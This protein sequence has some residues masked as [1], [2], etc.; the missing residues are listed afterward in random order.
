MY[1]LFVLNGGQLVRG[2]HQLLTKLKVYK[3]NILVVYKFGKSMPMNWYVAAV[4]LCHFFFKASL[5]LLDLMVNI[6]TD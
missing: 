6:K 2:N 1:G 5:L 4:S 3:P